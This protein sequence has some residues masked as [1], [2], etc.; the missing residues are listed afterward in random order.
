MLGKFIKEV[1]T[2]NY[3]KIVSCPGIGANLASNKCPLYVILYHSTT[4]PEKV[5]CCYPTLLS[6]ISFMLSRVSSLAS[7]NTSLVARNSREVFFRISRTKLNINLVSTK[8]IWIKKACFFCCLKWT[9]VLKVEIGKLNCLRIFF[10]HR[11]Y[12]LP[13]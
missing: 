1:F 11:S 4:S 9:L 12:L 8:Y 7:Y 6:A 5:Y 2:Y 3:Y 10:S 13:S